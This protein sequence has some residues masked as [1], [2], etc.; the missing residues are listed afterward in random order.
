MSAGARRCLPALALFAWAIAASGAAPALQ[1][2]PEPPGTVRRVLFRGV[3]HVRVVRR[4]PR[5]LVINV[6]LVDLREPGVRLVVTRPDR[7]YA[8]CVRGRTVSQFMR[9][10]RVQAAVNASNFAAAGPAPR[11]AGDTQLLAPDGTWA[12]NGRVYAR[13]SDA[14]W[15]PVTIGRGNRVAF[16]APVGRIETVLPAKGTMLRGGI[17][18]VGDAPVNRALHP[19]TAIATDR[20]GRV[21]VVIVVDGRQPGVSEGVTV[22][23]LAAIAAEFGAADGVNMDGGGSSAM[24]AEGAGG[25]SVALNVPI[26]RNMPGAERPVATHLGIRARRVPRAPG[27]P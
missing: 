27:G 15:P 26:D 1:T 18:C 25:A 10:Q 22:A 2:A 17:P 23:E 21:L 13:G 16:G 11:R 5:P 24:V 19:R 3:T 4:E 9:E 20:T 14:K 8:A 7:E 6:L 12:V